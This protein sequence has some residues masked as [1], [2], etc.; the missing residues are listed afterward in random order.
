MLRTMKWGLGALGLAAAAALGI[1]AIGIGGP[2]SA[3]VAPDNQQSN[4]Q[5]KVDR[6]R[7]LLA[8]ELGITVDQLTTAQTA[9]RNKLIDEELAAGTITQEQADRLKT[10][11]PGDGFGLRMGG[12][13]FGKAIGDIADSTAQILGLSVDELRTR[14]MNGETLLQIAQSQGVS[15]ADLKSG[16]IS[17]LTDKI[18][19]AV[20][21][22]DIDQDKADTLLAN[23]SDRV[24]RALSGERPFDGAGPRFGGHFHMGG[25]NGTQN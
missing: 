16:L 4:Q 13:R 24:D 21:A 15:E 25:M 18:N 14:I 2:A 17:A 10:M 7:E 12:H 20:T 6:Y 8:E 23:L 19:A 9:A 1:A 3:Q 11:Q 22:G 5:S